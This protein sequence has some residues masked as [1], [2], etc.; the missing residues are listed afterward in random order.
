MPDP[1]ISTQ[2][3]SV[4]AN[5]LSAHVA[6]CLH[7]LINQGY[8]EST[9][10]R[11]RCGLSHFSHWLTRDKITW[12]GQEEVLAG[13]FLTAHLPSCDCTGQFLHDRQ[14]LSAALHHLLRSLRT[15]G[16]ITAGNLGPGM[17]DEEVR[18]FDAYLER[19]CGLATKT[20]Q[21]RTHFV[22]RFLSARGSIDLTDCG[23]R[24][25]RQFVTEATQGWK[26]SSVAVLC[27]ALR[28][29]LRFRKLRGECTDALMAA[30]PSVAQWP[31]ASLP[32]ALTE[33][34]IERLL[35][36][37][38]RTTIEGRRNYAMA[39]CLVDL[40][41]RAG[42]VARLQLED[43]NWREG[44][45]QLRHTKS[46]RV[47]VLPL[48]V[49]TGQ[50]IVQY[51]QGRTARRPSRALFVRQRPP[52]DAP[53]TVEIVRSAIR[54]AYA[55]AG[56]PKP[57]SGTHCLRHS[58]ACHLVNAGVPLKEIADVLRHRDLNT[59]TIYAKVNLTQLAA[60][61]LPWPGRVS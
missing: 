3:T 19:I 55:R 11:Y 48:P 21:V 6:V 18:R 36:N 46:K 38:D 1:T 57:W 15:H 16:H 8:A 37:F 50:A 29:Y 22:R 49:R 58:L 53:L 24:Q 30:V 31:A 7:E 52:L 10:N 32:N 12:N 45:V 20:R 13:R 25:V 33:A 14:T 44:T 35:G 41:L 56:I 34:E 23:P 27:G 47:D 28:S 51:L 60:V 39:L 9:V 26:L 42:E 2:R 5:A 54:Q 59:T 40:G 17:I 43:L 61:A 4:E